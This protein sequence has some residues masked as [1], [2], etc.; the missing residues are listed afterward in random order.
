MGP[1]WAALL[2]VGC[3]E[4][5][6]RSLRASKFEF[7]MKFDGNQPASEPEALGEGDDSG[8]AI[9]MPQIEF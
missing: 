4:V 2:I 6:L 9:K 1:L 3:R 5:P 8:P 7:V